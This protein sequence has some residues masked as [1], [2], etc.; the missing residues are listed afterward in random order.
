MASIVKTAWFGRR[1]SVLMV[2]DKTV[3]GTLSEVT[4]NYL[5]LKRGGS[6]TQVMFHAI[7]AVRPASEEGGD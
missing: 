4:D 6:E 2:N 7:I 3:T 5:I 1:V